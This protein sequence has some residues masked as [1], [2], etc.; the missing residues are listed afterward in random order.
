MSTRIEGGEGD[1][2]FGLIQACLAPFGRPA[3]AD[4][5]GPLIGKDLPA[6]KA[7]VAAAGFAGRVVAWQTWAALPVHD[8]DSFLAFATA[9]LGTKKFLDGLTPEARMEAEG[10]LRTAGAAALER[11]A[12]QIPVAV[13]VAWC[14]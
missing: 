5:E 9:P 2:A 3:P 11:G 7:R 12:I 10:S 4:R 8:A 14:E 1:T 13:V 6:L